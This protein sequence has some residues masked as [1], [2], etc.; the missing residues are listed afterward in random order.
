MNAQPWLNPLKLPGKVDIDWMSV[1]TLFLKGCVERSWKSYSHSHRSTF[2]SRLHEQPGS[3]RLL[4]ADPWL[5]L[6]TAEAA[7]PR[8]ER[9]SLRNLSPR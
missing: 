7:N 2:S 5:P 9:L 1:L 8:A 3:L 4:D 6:A